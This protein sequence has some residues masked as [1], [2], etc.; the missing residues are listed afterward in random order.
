MTLI[1]ANPW[2]A[3]FLAHLVDAAARSL[4][5]AAA[6]ALALAALRIRSAALRL[7][8]WTAV[9][10]AAL[11]M[12]LL[13]P[14]LPRLAVPMPSFFQASA[15][16]SPSPRGRL[17]PSEAPG[18]A[19]LESGMIRRES[20]SPAIVPRSSRPIPS[21]PKAGT[22]AFASLN[23]PML[24]LGLY[25]VVASVLLLRFFIGL[26]FNRRLVRTCRM[27]T[28][29]RL[30]AGLASR[31][32]DVGLPLAPPAGESEFT[33]V[34]VTIGAIGSM[35]LLPASWREWDDR[36]LDAVLAHEISHVARRD[37]LTQHLSLLH[38]AI[39]WFSPLA[40]WLDGHLAGLAEQASDEAALS[41]GADRDRYAQTLLEFLEVLHAAPG[42]VWWQGLAMAKSGQA[43]KRLERILHWRGA[44]HMSSKTSGFEKSLSIAAMA[45]TV[46]IAF[47][48]AS[49]APATQRPP[50]GWSQPPAPRT[51]QGSAQPASVAPS[52]VSPAITMRALP[53]PQGAQLRPP[54]SPESLAPVAP[55]VAQAMRI[56]GSLHG[57]F[58]VDED[59]QRFVIVSGKTD[60]VTMSGS[61]Q[62]AHHAE[63]LKK[64][65]NGDF[66][67]FQHDEKSYI[68][69]DQATV[70]RAR[71]LWAPQEEL[72]RKQEE[73]GKQ[74]E[75]LGKQQEALGDKQR[76]I[77]VKVPDMTAELDKLKAEL[78]QL[79]SGA[80]QEQLGHIQSEI[81][82]L[83]S[84]IGDMQSQAGE[85]QSKLGE[86]QGRLGEQQGELG[87]RQ[88]E[89]G[90]QQG[91]LSERAS[92]Q[93]R[94]LLDEALKNG[95]AQPEPGPGNL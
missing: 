12:P 9:L 20:E 90:R 13:G 57:N 86:Q 78:K 28:D 67:W 63:R 34:P 38:R 10:Y 5:L 51:D 21:R 65:I 2:S 11:A 91:E 83:Q 59:D 95:T 19:R 81:G 33:S 39:F 75:A 14:F 45:L 27:I 50:L 43:E 35:I 55:V 84:R 3:A 70:D 93:M 82:D 66:I 89:L 46:L 54:S 24:T 71:Q 4:I 16:S 30:R 62:D 92:R 52:P 37:P 64:Q 23:W 47:L 7:A 77:Q 26:I 60:A 36:K 61:S 58:N 53:L 56:E 80:T 69:R 87:R 25:L 73:L 76:Q 94:E 41:G 15:A 88:G 17:S 40:W 18:S 68:I 22:S 48:T 42:R 31:A 85:Q 32:H 1:P 74:Q 49:V 72:G 6:V 44:V 29:P 8:A 79:G